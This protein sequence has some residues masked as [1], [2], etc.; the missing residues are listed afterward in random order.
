MK[1]VEL[2]HAGFE[3]KFHITTSEHAKIYGLKALKPIFFQH[4]LVDKTKRNK[5]NGKRLL[6]MVQEFAE[7]NS[8]YLPHKEPI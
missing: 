1:S 2:E 8:I 6:D 7:N 3:I 5:G 4:L